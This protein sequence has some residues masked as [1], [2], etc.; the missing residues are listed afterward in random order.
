MLNLP[1]GCDLTQHSN[2][3]IHPSAIDNY[4]CQD[5]H[6]DGFLPIVTVCKRYVKL[7]SEIDIRNMITEIQKNGAR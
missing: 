4:S 3:Y 6:Y 5:P 2:V 1:K 7:V